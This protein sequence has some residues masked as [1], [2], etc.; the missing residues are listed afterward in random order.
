MAN[1]WLEIGPIA[2]VL[3]LLALVHAL[4]WVPS[5]PYFNNDEARH[6]MT[7]VFMRDALADGGWT[8]PRDYATRYYLQYP[9]LGLLVWPPLFYAVEGV[10]MWLFG[11]SFVVARLTI[12]LFTAL[13]CIY[14]YRLVWLTSGSRL[15]ATWAA[16]LLG[17]GPLVLR[18]SQQ[19]MLEVPTLAWALMAIFHFERYLNEERPRDALL[20]CLAAAAAALTRFDGVVLLPYFVIR[21]LATRRW[22]VLKRP[23]V[24]A[25]LVLAMLLAGPY[26]AYTWKVYGGTIQKAAA[27][28]TMPDSTTFRPERNLPFYPVRIYRHAGPLLAVAAV[29][30]LIVAL[31]RRRPIGVSLALMLAV[32]LTFTPLAELEDRHAIYWVPALCAL[33]AEL[34]LALPPPA[35][36]ST[37]I[38]LVGAAMAQQVIEPPRYVFGYADAAHT[39]MTRERQANVV[40]FDGCLSAGFIYQVRR[41]DPLREVTVL[42]GDK[43]VYGVLSDPA[44]GY[45]ERATSAEEIL[46][47][48]HRYDPDWIVLEAPQAMFPD[49]PAPKRLRKTLL[50]HPERYERVPELDVPLRTD[51]L[52]FTRVV[53]EFYRPKVRNPNREQLR[54]IPMLNLTQPVQADQ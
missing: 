9:G 8:H 7:G 10:A 23:P 51:H 38:I 28:G 26:Y 16:L 20:S 47:L 49:L 17:L 31:R 32:Y 33:G 41:Y 46:T 48:L 42:R 3:V 45:E 29:V 27:E 24:L 44:G 15:A 54:E 36:W 19:V 12:L 43:L 40:F 37:G 52:A 22:N 35:R 18:H 13:A 4:F 6:V 2:G 30:G 14:T 25:G 11:T 5:E 39:V 34:L 21:L 53:L 50:D 1:R